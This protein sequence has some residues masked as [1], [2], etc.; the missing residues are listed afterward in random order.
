MITLQYDNVYTTILGV[1]VY[2]ISQLADYLSVEY[3]NDAGEI[4]RYSFLHENKFLSGLLSR[5]TE[6]LDSR[7]LPYKVEGLKK[8]PE[9]DL[10]PLV[11]G[12]TLRPYQVSAVE[13]ILRLKRGVVNLPTAAG[14]SE[15]LAAL[16]YIVDKPSLTI[17]GISDHAN[18]L[19]RLLRDERGLDVG[20]IGDGEID[21][22]HKHLV[23][24]T[25][26]L[27]NIVRHNKRGLRRVRNRLLRSKIFVTDECH[28]QPNDSSS[29][30]S[31]SIPAEYRI[32][33]SASP[34][35]ND[36]DIYSNY[37][38]TLLTGLTGP[39]ICYIPPVVLVREGFL[40]E[41]IVY[42]VETASDRLESWDNNWHSV[43]SK[44]IVNN[45]L[46]NSD[47]CE[48]IEIIVASRDNP[49]VL[50]I[51]GVVEH[52]RV[53]LRMLHERGLRNVALC[54]GQTGPVTLDSHGNEV[55]HDISNLDFVKSHIS[56]YNVVIGSPIFDEAVNI[57]TI[58]DVVLAEGGRSP[59]R[60]IQRIGR[61]MR[62]SP[63]KDRVF[64]WD[65]ADK[66]HF[67]LE[68]QFKFRLEECIK[69]QFKHYVIQMDYIRQL[70]KT[71]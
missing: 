61:G 46:R 11:N 18:Q 52:G 37:S 68:R 9:V 45:K 66:C 7:N 1:D 20:L 30:V 59:R 32:G 50:C 33:L 35:V 34:Y 60:N 27:A 28:H 26:S 2:T 3:E 63:G 13:K 41:P 23:G 54:S 55:S 24:V 62:K 65:I 40:A 58:T 21:Y 36:E 70:R 49:L 25:K 42:F 6:F 57:P 8:I 17:I 5:V 39:M 12:I 31:K 15:I 29:F 47:I 51:I 53:L 67:F 4:I 19:V 48:L 10:D 16:L 44:G 71:S 14:K 64:I 22:K 43:R 69:H 56:N 38:D